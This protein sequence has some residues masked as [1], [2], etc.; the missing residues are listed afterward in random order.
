MEEEQEELKSIEDDEEDDQFSD[1][2]DEFPITKCT[3][4]EEE[5]ESIESSSDICQ[6]ESKES[7]DLSNEQ[8]GGGLRRRRSGKQ[9]EEKQVS[10]SSSIHDSVVLN[11]NSTL[12]SGVFQGISA[13][14]R[15]NKILN[16][17]KACE[18]SKEEKE[19]DNYNNNSSLSETTTTIENQESST[20]NNVNSEMNV[21]NHLE[22]EVVNNINSSS[23]SGFLVNL[24]GLVIKAIGFQFS[25]L[26]S[27]LSFPIW[28]SYCL[29]MFMVDPFRMMKRAKDGIL[30]KFNGVWHVVSEIFAPF[31]YE[32]LKEHKSIGKFALKFG[33][34]FFWSIYICIVLSGFLL[35]G[36]VIGGLIIRYLIEKP[37]QMTEDLNFDYTRAS[38]V[39]FVP[40]M[41]CPNSYSGAKYQDDVGKSAVSPVFPSNH[42]LQLTISLTMPESDYN[43]KLGVF[44]VRVDF[45]SQNGEVTASSRHP[46]MLQF[47][48]HI[49][50]YL[51]TILKSVPLLAGYTSEAQVLNIKMRG[52]S[53]GYK[54]TSCIRVILEQRAEFRSGAGIPEIYSASLL[55]ESELP[56]FKRV[57]WYWKRTIFVWISMVSFTMELMLILLCCRPVLIPRARSRENSTPSNAPQNTVAPVRSS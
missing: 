53:E 30:E 20:S 19:V 44:Q 15:R 46:C 4:E 36:F 57:I 48:S 52:F 13:I 41:F 3:E 56:L 55:L 9:R 12:N 18:R 37:I 31:V 1:A 47:K 6:I 29:L 17:L 45:L 22:Q 34:G 14:E 10:S 26:V 35:T 42:K 40:I 25:L 7:K 11:S 51:E 33:W 54:P 24:A 50:H 27:F 5:E 23:S 43:R 8:I 21:E 32:K 39:A 16:A 49:L 28:F 38:P 2:F